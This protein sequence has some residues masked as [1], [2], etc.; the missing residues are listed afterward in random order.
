LSAATPFP[1]FFSHIYP[2]GEFL[3]NCLVRQKLIRRLVPFDFLERVTPIMASKFAAFGAIILNCSSFFTR[4]FRVSER[5]S[6][7]GDVS[8]GTLS[9]DSFPFSVGNY[10]PRRTSPVF[11]FL[12]SPFSYSSPSLFFLGAGA[13]PRFRN[14]AYCSSKTPFFPSSNA[15]RLEIV[16]QK[17]PHVSPTS[18]FLP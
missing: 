13:D 18:I 11:F 1:L 7:S 3:W 16:P 8:P 15:A 4:L 17:T 2:G 14:L 9:S 5:F 6:L 10:L 12:F